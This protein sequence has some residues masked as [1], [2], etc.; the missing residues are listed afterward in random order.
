MMHLDAAGI[1]VRWKIPPEAG[2]SVRL[3][4]SQ[5]QLLVDDVPIAACPL[6]DSFKHFVCESVGEIK[7]TPDTTLSATGVLTVSTCIL[8]RNLDINYDFSE[9]PAI[10]GSCYSGGS[11]IS[12]PLSDFLLEHESR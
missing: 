4:P 3:S 2:R 10:V 6:I 1:T 8:D 5:L 7:H 9:S 12:T 11:L